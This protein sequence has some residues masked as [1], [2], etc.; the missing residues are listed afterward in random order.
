MTIV[1]ATHLIRHNF[2]QTFTHSHV[3]STDKNLCHSRWDNDENVNPASQHQTMNGYF[4][5]DKLNSIMAGLESHIKN[6][7]PSNF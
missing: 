2:N 4:L 3:R 6:N 7:N 5:Y 1:I